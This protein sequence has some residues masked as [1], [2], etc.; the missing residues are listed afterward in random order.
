MC[1]CIK[2]NET[3]CGF[4][5]INHQPTLNNCFLF[6][7]RTKVKV[8]MRVKPVKVS[9]VRFSA[10][11]WWCQRHI[12][13]GQSCACRE[14]S[15]S[16][17]YSF[18]LISLSKC[19]RFKFNLGRTPPPAAVPL[20]P[21]PCVSTTLLYPLANTPSPPPSVRPHRLNYTSSGN[22]LFTG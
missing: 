14:A 3:G 2:K 10:Y 15:I 1:P 19:R 7:F 16:F 6:K 11:S 5:V 22:V 4:H 18:N 12:L 20:T 8:Q 9:V 21:R 13:N 17:N